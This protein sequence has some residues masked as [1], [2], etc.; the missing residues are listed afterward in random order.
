MRKSFEM[1]IEIPSDLSVVG[2]DDVPL[3]QYVLPPLTTVEMSQAELARLA[4]EALL[5]EVSRPEPSPVGTEFELKTALVLR[6][7]TAAPAQAK[8]PR[9]RLP[10]TANA[11][12]V[13]S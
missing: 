2:F 9:K 6:E 7:S 10:G 11:K 3:A 4:L 1:K 13:R 12:R 5:S 8:A